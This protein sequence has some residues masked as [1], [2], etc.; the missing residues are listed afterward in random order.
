MNTKK[1]VFA[2]LFSKEAAKAQK[3]SKQRKVKFSLADDL[4]RIADSVFDEIRDAEDEVA[5]SELILDQFATLAFEAEE[6][7]DVL[8]RA[9]NSIET[10]YNE[11]DS[12]LANYADACDELGIDPRSNENYVAL[13]ALN[14][15]TQME[16]VFSNIDEY[17]KT[18]TPIIQQI[19]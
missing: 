11:I 7:A 12:V 13:E 6:Q 4:S 5:S 1:V 17:M 9:R 3:L 19:R 2:K 18:I 16:D 15:S 10:Y 8:L 14:N